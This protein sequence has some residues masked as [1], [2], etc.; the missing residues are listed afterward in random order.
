MR[1]T[2]IIDLSEF[3]AL[4]RSASVR[5]LYMHM[6]F[7]SGY[8]D[9]DRDMLLT[10]IRRL[11]Q[12][13][14]LTVGAVRHALQQLETVSLITKDGQLYR[15]KKYILERPITARAKSRRQE[16]QQA[17]NAQLQA[18]KEERE[19]QYRQDELR[20]R[21]LAASGKSDYIM[22]VESLM[23]KAA[24][25]DIHAAEMVKMHQANYNKAIADLKAN[26][27]HDS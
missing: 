23:E 26:I 8:H 14:G 11:A 2:T 9:D 19:R 10:S 18:E 5:L 24:R 7:K 16:E 25:G 20:R 22:Y 21:K 13:T 3:P 15:I 12:E 27:N 17:A 4:Y 6:V 1:Y